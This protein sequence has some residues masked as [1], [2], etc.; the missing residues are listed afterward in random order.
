MNDYLKSRLAQSEQRMSGEID[1]LE[2]E[3]RQSQE[4]GQVLLALKKEIDGLKHKPEGVSVEQLERLIAKLAPVVNIAETKVNV[5]APKI[6]AIKIPDI[7]IPETVVNV[8]PAI[9]TLPEQNV[10]FETPRLRSIKFTITG[11]DRSGALLE[12]EAEPIYD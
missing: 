4:I 7:K 11:R 1:Y 12:F 9:V 10:T 6:P 5:A 2:V 3:H 8:S